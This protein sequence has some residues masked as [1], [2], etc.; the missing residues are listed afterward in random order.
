[1]PKKI[2]DYIYPDYFTILYDGFFV[3]KRYN[4]NI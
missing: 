2:G 4:E 3:K 1:M